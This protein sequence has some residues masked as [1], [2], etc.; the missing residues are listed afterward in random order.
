MPRQE[1]AGSIGSVVM[2]RFIQH[3]LLACAFIW[4]PATAQTP[5]F[6]NGPISIVVPLAPGDAADTTARAMGDEIARLLNTS[7]QA[8]NRPGAGG[9][10]GATA[11]CRP[12]KTARRSFS[13]RTACSP[14]AR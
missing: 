13:P 2:Q 7:V 12:R 14:F 10:L 4:L 9:A 11:S 6:P 8:I 3:T 5:P 1:S